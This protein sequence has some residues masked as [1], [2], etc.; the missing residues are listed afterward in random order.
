MRIALAYLSVILIWTTTPLA[1]KWSAE[2]AGVIFGA[3]SRMSIGLFCLLLIL[4]IRRR[5]IA[6]HKAA[7]LTYLAVALQI[8]AAMMAVYWGAQFVPSGWVSVI[9][10]LT[11]FITALL[12]AIILKERS[13]TPGKLCAY[14]LGFIG[15]AMM[16]NSALDFSQQAIQG[17]VG[18]LFAGFLHSLSA[19]WV[20][21]IGAKLP[22]TSQVAGGLLL[23]TPLYLITWYVLDQARIPE[24]LSIQTMAAIVYLGIFATTF[25]FAMYYFLLTHLAATTVSLITIICP[26][27][28]L[29]V[30]NIVNHEPITYKV[31]IST[32]IILS[33][34]MIYQLD[35]LL[36]KKRSRKGLVSS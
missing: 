33:A 14:L 1:I 21:Q 10:G 12:A 27:L 28:A 13:L 23:A 36:R 19:V 4:L 16:F 34:L 32:A 29:Y 9:F 15:L 5:G 35:D 20:K 22:A 11:P 3:A 30:G 6:W 7:V 2:G 8:Y 31:M 18:I 26:I 17:I 24:N 25:G